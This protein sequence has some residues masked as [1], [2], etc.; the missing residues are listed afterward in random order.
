MWSLRLLVWSLD[1]SILSSL[2]R[3][4]AWPPPAAL[5][6]PISR[7]LFLFAALSFLPSS[8]PSSPSLPPS[9]SRGRKVSA[10]MISQSSV[11]VA[12]MRRIW[13][14]EWIEDNGEVDH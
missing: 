7:F 12:T 2:E 11:A 3:R 1:L 9:L 8:P 4:A 5:L 14:R 13:D 6:S 10:Q